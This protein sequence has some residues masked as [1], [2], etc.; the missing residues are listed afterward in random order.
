VLTETIAPA[1]LSLQLD[2]LL[3]NCGRAVDGLS[4][5]EVRSTHGDRTNSAGFDV[6]HVSR[7]VDNVIHFVFERERPVWLTEGFYEAWGLP[8]VEQGTDMEPATAYALAF[9][10]AAELKR[11]AEAVRAAVVPRVAAMSDAYL[12]EITRILPW[13]E[14]P[15]YRAIVQVLIGHG[16]AHL[17]RVELARALLGKEGLGI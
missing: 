9:P 14:I 5:D 13:G 11:Y 17:G 8:R 15:R 4:L 2:R 6:W 3:E 10:E 16:N 1:E 12:A 7:T